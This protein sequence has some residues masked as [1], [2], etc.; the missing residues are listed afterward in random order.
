MRTPKTLGELLGKARNRIR[1][2]GI[3]L[4]GGWVTLPPGTELVRDGSVSI[5]QEIPQDLMNAYRGATTMAAQTKAHKAIS[6]W[7]E[8]HPAPAHIGELPSPPMEPERIKD[9]LKKF[10]PSHVNA[11]CGMH[12]HMSFNTK[13][14]YQRLMVPEYQDAIVEY[15]TKWA[16]VTLPAEHGIFPRLA[17]TNV[18][19]RK[20][21]WPDQQ[22]SAMKKEYN[23]GAGVNRYTMI[24]YAHG[25]HG[26]IECRVLPMMENPELAYEAISEVLRITNAFI[27][28]QIRKEIAERIV[29]EDEGDGEVVTF[30]A[31][32]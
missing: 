26:T 16:E 4:E 11:T 19:C 10:Y 21:F 8:A 27:L 30:S 24:H 9:F 15:L 31:A 17:G 18:F 23:R 32:L 2:V 20:N 5:E 13:L 14:T 25:T 1:K 29:I 6:A 28:T 3:E 7:Q 12:V 22:A